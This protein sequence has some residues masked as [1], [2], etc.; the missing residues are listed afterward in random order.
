MS[1]KKKNTK[2]VDDELKKFDYFSVEQHIKEKSMWLGTKN[3]GKYEEWVLNSAD[4]VF[5]KLELEYSPALLKCFW[6]LTCNAIDASIK[7]KNVKNI[8]LGFNRETG[9]FYIYNDGGGIPVKFDKRVDQWLPEAIAT[10]PFSG[11]NLKANKDRRTGGTNGLG[12]KLCNFFAKRLYL[13]SNDGENMFSQEYSNRMKDKSEPIVSKWN[14]LKKKDQKAHVYIEFEP[15]WKGFTYDAAGPN[16]LQ[17]EH[18]ETLVQ[19]MAYQT[20]AYVR[21]GVIVKYNDE[22]V[23][24]NTLQ[25]YAKMF[26]ENIITLTLPHPTDPWE[27]VLAVHDG[28]T[29]EHQSFVNGIYVRGGGDH[30]KAIEN[31]L[32]DALKEK[33]QKILKENKTTRFNRNMITNHIFLFHRGDVAN[34]DFDGQRKD[35]LRAPPKTFKDYELPKA[36]ITKFW[37]MLSDQIL[38]TYAQKQIDSDGG[39]KRGKLNI[40][41]LREADIVSTKK[42]SAEARLILSEGNTADTMVRRMLT[43]DKKL[44]FKY[45][46]VYNLRGVPMNARKEMRMVKGVKIRSKK[47]N[48]ETNRLMN[49]VRILGLDFTQNYKTKESLSTLRYGGVI[50]MVDQDIDGVGNIQ[51]LTLNCIDVFWPNLL[52]HGYFQQLNTPLIRVFPKGKKSKIIEF[53]SELSYNNWKEEQFKG[54]EPPSAKFKIKYYKGLGTHEK[55]STKQIAK[56]FQNHLTTWVGD[57]ESEKLFEAFFGKATDVRKVELA[58][59]MTEYPEYD[60]VK[61]VPCSIHLM[62]DTKL[63]QN[64]K[65]FRNLKCVTDGLTPSRRKV[66]MGA[67]DKFAKS[68]DSIKVFQ[69]G[70]AVASDYNYHHGDASLNGTITSMGQTFPGSNYYPILRGMGEFGSRMLGGKDAGQPRYIE[71]SLNKELVQLLFPADD[72]YMLEYRFEDGQRTEPKEWPTVI[73]IVLIETFSGI[74]TGWKQ[75]NWAREVYGVIENVK[76]KIKEKPLKPFQPET[77]GFKGTFRMVNDVEHCIGAYELKKERIGK[78]FYDAIHITELPIGIWTKPYLDWLAEK[79]IDYIHDIREICGGDNVDIL[80]ILK[81]GSMAEIN[82][83]F[84]TE[85]LTPVEHGFDLYTSA[86]CWLNF[87]D[88][89]GIVH[90][91]KKVE[92]VFNA[93]FEARKNLYH[94][95]LKRLFIITKLRIQ[96]LENIIR[97]S[98]NYKEYKLPGKKEEEVLSIIEENAFTKFVKSPVDEPKYVS[99]EE[100]E[101]TY[102]G[103]GATYDYLVGLSTKNMYKSSIERY[104]AHLKEYQDVLDDIKDKEDMWLGAKF[105]L[106]ELDQIAEVIKTGRETNWMFGHMNYNWE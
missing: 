96:F 62:R 58:K 1:N 41:G 54:G 50:M 64:E 75:N 42:G 68:D 29:F 24:I 15:F 34:P 20:A 72:R 47:W 2:E 106:R 19:T 92:D 56:T 22:K 27:I 5:S 85:Q 21:K 80:V 73:P 93:W 78:K 90:E 105:W 67:S 60:G 11:S 94:L 49:V 95:R 86:Q 52:K 17:M 65:N 9:V 89:E 25:D 40:E 81:E 8:S 45:Y 26:C 4:K 46:G 99:L 100:L 101:S 74:G 14:D 98:E 31:L 79:R 77:Y 16:E 87:T 48:N 69:L 3:I 71:A 57:K 12:L 88:K 61:E 6:E 28:G 102:L 51:S 30:I 36:G 55:E 38:A 43:S 39:K 104:K 76:R 32:V 18:L 7:N 103:E 44:G 63:F 83:N 97:F 53:Y 82:K 66:L 13:E 33:T 70:A 84:G 91:Y 37:N 23:P 10:N 59:P 35:Q